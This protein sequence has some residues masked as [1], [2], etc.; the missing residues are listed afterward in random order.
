MPR[1]FMALV[2]PHI[3]PLGGMLAHVV[4]REQDWPISESCGRFEV[5]VHLVIRLAGQGP[6]GFLGTKRSLQCDGILCVAY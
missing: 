3:H 5:E 2:T 4:A 6:L 1:F